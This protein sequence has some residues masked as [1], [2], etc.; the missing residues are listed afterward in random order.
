MRNRVLGLL[1]CIALLV[2]APCW[3]DDVAAKGQALLDQYKDAVV[4]VHVVLSM[5]MGGEEH[6]Q[7]NW[8]H[9]TVLNGDGVAVTS[10]TQVDPMSFYQR[11]SDEDEG[12]TTKVVS[13]DMVL[14]DGTEIPSEIVLRD[15]ELD[16]AYLRPV[17][18]PAAPM[19]HVDIEKL[20]TP[21]LL[22]QVALIQRMGQVARR[23]HGV[24]VERVEAVI[25]K[26]RP[27][28]VVGENRSRSVVGSPVFLLDGSFAGV[29][30]IRAIRSENGASA[31]DNMLIIVVPARDVVDGMEQVTPR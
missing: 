31:G 28:Y 15:K 18:A 10:L 21:E 19:T 14:G 2:S 7:T 17:E 12:I 24:F 26:P 5:Q 13:M 8:A 16:L 11:M 6:E 30:A 1:S 4:S 20:G 25:P 9:A 22:D 29:G 27:Y 23:A 3:G